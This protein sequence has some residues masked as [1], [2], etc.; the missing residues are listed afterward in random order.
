[1]QPSVVVSI[2][3][4]Y[5][6]FVREANSS[7]FLLDPLTKAIVDHGWLDCWG[8]GVD[9]HKMRNFAFVSEL[10]FV[11]DVGKKRSENRIFAFD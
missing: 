1:L 5:L 2:D 7:L 3:F 4:G 8:V 11:S 6:D 9:E 10:I